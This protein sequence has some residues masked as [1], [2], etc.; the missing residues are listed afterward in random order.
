MI[1]LL[2]AV[3]LAQSAPT[4]ARGPRTGGD[5]YAT[6][7]IS[8]HGAHLEGTV[9]APTLRG[10]G[11]AAVDWALRTGEMPLEVPGTEPLPG[12]P[13]FSPP[14][15]DALISYIVT[16]GGAG[17]PPIPQVS[18]SA[19]VMRGRVV[20]EQNCQAC[21]G[22]TAAGAIAGFGWLAPPLRDVPATQ[23]AEAVRIGPGMMPRFDAHAIPPRDLDALVTYVGA[24][25]HPDDR[26]G[27][28]MANIGPVAEGL[29]GWVVGL[30][31]TIV[32][33]LAVGETTKR[34]KRDA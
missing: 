13:A 15:I 23:V 32:L 10:V 33:M 16:H 11:A 7:C 14:Q 18:R 24:L 20:F 28:P 34:S 22:A 21:H 4:A 12:A 30:G 6:H 1:A 9:D 8:C 29:V 19:D 27:Y 31:T 26:G 25:R 3:V 17:G 2:A 5:L